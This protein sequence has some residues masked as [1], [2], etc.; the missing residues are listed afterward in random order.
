MISFENSDS[1]K[2][3][4]VFMN[5]YRSADSAALKVALYL[6]ECGT[7]DENEIAEA[8]GIS[9]SSVERSLDFWK[10]AG[11]FDQKAIA[12]DINANSQIQPLKRHMNH[13]DIASL[14]MTDNNISLLLQETQKLL[15]RELSF[16]ESRLL[17]E[18]INDTQLD[19]E[20]ILMIEAYYQNTEHSKKVLT[21]S[22]RTARDFV[23]EGISSFAS[24]QDR[25]VLFEKRYHDLLQVAD[26]LSTDP[27]DI[28]RKERKL[29]NRIYEEYGYDISF[30]SEV[31]IRK[32]D[33]NLPYIDAVLKDWH[34]KGYKTISDTRLLSPA[35]DAYQMTSQKQET[36]S[37]STLKQAVK[38]NRK[39]R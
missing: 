14:I 3:P 12:K 31:L 9:L 10:S 39:E 34:K 28:S 32:P 38:R 6:F 20:S 8:L 18:T 16:S 21:D 22:C 23:K 30:V 1:V 5:R 11:L 24:V 7:A 19:A 4:E 35:S 13:S 26:A 17:V 36:N 37:E 27:G 25:I 29:I 2:L 15:G 33:A